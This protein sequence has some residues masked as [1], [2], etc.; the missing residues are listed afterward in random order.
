VAPGLIP[1][2]PAAE[3]G[4]FAGVEET[5]VEQRDSDLIALIKASA[6]KVYGSLT[7][8]I[9]SILAIVVG[10]VVVVIGMWESPAKNGT[11]AAFALMLVFFGTRVLELERLNW[12]LRQM[13]R[14][15]TSSQGGPPHQPAPERGSGS[16]EPGPAADDR[17]HGC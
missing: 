12:K 2:E 7:W 4:S 13:V 3:R 8:I 1:C 15:R 6:D 10:I 5:Q 14:G 11:L 9:L 17:G 16:A